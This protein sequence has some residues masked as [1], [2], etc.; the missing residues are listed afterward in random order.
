MKKM[1]LGL[2]FLAIVAQVSSQKNLPPVYTITTD[3]VDYLIDS[4]FI[5]VLADPANNLT[6]DSFAAPSVSEAFK[7][8]PA[9]KKAE[10]L[11]CSS[12]WI[13]VRTKNQ[14]ANIAKLSLVSTANKANF[15]L[16]DSTGI[17]AHY[18][19]GSAYSYNERDG[20]KAAFS[21]PFTIAPG[22]TITIYY[23]RFNEE[24]GLPKKLQVTFLNTEKVAAK[25]LGQYERRYFNGDYF[26]EPAFLGMLILAAIFNFFFFL[27]VR[28]RVYLY[29]C[30]FVLT[31]S[32]GEN[33]IIPDVFFSGNVIAKH[34]L[35]EVLLIWMYFLI[36]FVRYYFKTTQVL[37]KWDRV[38][39]GLLL[40]LLL[41]FIASLF[42][43]KY[44][45]LLEL[46][47]GVTMLL[48][49]FLLFFAIPFTF[50][51]SGSAGRFFLLAV[52][53]FISSPIVLIIAGIAAALKNQFIAAG[54]GDLSLQPIPAWF[55]DNF[56]ASR[57][58][59]IC[60]AVV[61]FTW[62]LFY[63]YNKQRKELAQQSI[64]KETMAKEQEIERGKL[65]EQQKVQ[66]E[67]DVAERTAELKQS[68]E[69]LKS[70]QKQLIQSEKMA[71]LGELTAGI[72]HEIQNPLNFVN[73]FS[74]VSK[75][76]LDEMDIE[77]DKG[78][79]TEAKT[80]SADIKQ[81]LE[82]INHH[83]KRADAIVKG[84]LQHSLKSTGHKELIDINVLAGE[85]MRLSYN[86]LRAKDKN[87]V[88][89][90]GTNFDQNL[91]K[92]KIIPQD[93]GRVLL[94]VLNNAF[95]A[96]TERRRVA[97]EGF[98]PFVSISTKVIQ[99][100]LA[101]SPMASQEGF[102]VE[103]TII[104][105]G[106]GIPKSIVNKIFQPFFTTKPTGQGTGLGLSLSYDIVTAHGGE[107]RVETTEGEGSR[108]TI[109]LPAS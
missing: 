88:A 2:L 39:K 92:I 77:L 12:Y 47:N 91:P 102:R 90:L 70:A 85:A 56:Y 104:D 51:K 98:K 86:G 30:L 13:R 18:K 7:P 32:I 66:L 59:T 96:T 35:E 54:N 103:I 8:L 50:K 1:L 101:P 57:N 23:N 4:N 84:M 55:S 82:K 25:A 61:V 24:K 74:E 6:M 58:A 28:E 109:L 10:K 62:A 38:M 26:F 81:N 5:Q 78:D 60:W 99:S 46:S 100:P 43:A 16:V 95:W 75:E 9:F 105:N 67:K 21:I 48:S 33:Y 89:E 42:L 73:N 65:I 79:I 14:S 3:S 69:E 29:F 87:F 76:L 97:G 49:F 17:I 94:N 31:Y 64:D 22:A 40:L 41:Q 34:I 71:S 53:P 80:I 63:R 19:T 44:A 37:P 36:Q 68:L 15:Y 45:Y 106:I 27:I 11:P 72:A 20:F 107:I 83:G 52:A 93:I 108:F